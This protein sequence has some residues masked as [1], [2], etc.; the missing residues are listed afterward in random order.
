MSQKPTVTT[1][2][3]SSGTNPFGAGTFYNVFDYTKEDLIEHST[4][5]G[6]IGPLLRKFQLSKA[7]MAAIVEGIKSVAQLSDI[8]LLLIVGWGLVPFMNLWYT[9]LLVTKTAPPLIATST[10]SST[11]YSS[12]DSTHTAMVDETTTNQEFRLLKPFEK[13]K[14]YHFFN[15][16]SELARLGML[17]YVADLVKIFLLGVGFEISKSNRLTHVFSYVVYTI[18]IFYRL[19]IIKGYILQKMVKKS[20]ADPGRIQV[21]N[22]FADAGLL[23]I[24]VFVLYEILNLQMGLA[25][26][27]VVAMGSVWTLVVSLAMKDIAR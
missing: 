25:L 5:A 19:S 1:S 7:Q 13:T 23:V 12:D 26:R 10:S 21:I 9:K 11:A 27:G 8:T 3:T 2:S 18:W 22:R 15:T 16:L 14:L 6:Q 24:A 4:I 20:Q 17:V